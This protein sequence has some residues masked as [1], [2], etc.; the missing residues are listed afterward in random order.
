MASLE[1]I[2]ITLNRVEALANDILLKMQVIASMVY[3]P[4][5]LSDIT[6]DLGLVKAGEFRSGKG[7]PGFGFTG[8]RMGA[9]GWVYGASRY[10]IA[11]LENDAVQFGLSIDNGKI[12]AGA[13][14]LT[15]DSLGMSI[16]SGT[17]DYNQIKFVD[18]ELIC[19]RIFQD[20]RDLYL[21][22]FQNASGSPAGG[23]VVLRCETGGPNGDSYGI[24]DP[25]VGWYVSSV[26]G[27]ANV[28]YIGGL[29]SEKDSTV[30]DVYGYHPLTTRAS[31]TDWDGDSYST[32]AK[33]LL[34]LSASFG[35][36]AGVKAVDVEVYVS[37]S[38]SLATASA[39]IGLILGPDDTAGIGRYFACNGYP[40]GVLSRTHA[41]VPCDSNGDMYFQIVATGAN[42]LNAYIR[43]WGYYI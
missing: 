38:D 21:H 40:N 34:D 7:E 31:S 12:Y 39:F 2:D 24:L 26:F 27:N 11:G 8:I 1:Q 33:T 18:G 10:A 36:P 35:L 41:V 43:I 25:D 19:G 28:R 42:T 6:E 20:D 37:D 30:H 14:A 17:S 32:T 16:H 22:G 9:P 15:L 3:A 4:G 13:G 29:Q 23:R 5:G